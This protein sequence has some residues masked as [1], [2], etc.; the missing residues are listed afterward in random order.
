MNLL[1]EFATCLDD[2]PLRT[3]LT[4]IFIP[5]IVYSFPQ[6]MLQQFAPAYGFYR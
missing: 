5:H 4:I 3:R 2:I 1:A 6:F